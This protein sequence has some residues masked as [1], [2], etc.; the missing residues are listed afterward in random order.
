V[1][2]SDPRVVT[3]CICCPTDPVQRDMI[4]ECRVTTA[5]PVDVIVPDASE[6]VITPDAGDAGDVVEVDAADAAREDAALLMLGQA[7]SSGAQ[8]GTGFCVDEV[9]C[10]SAC[11]PSD[12][13]SCLLE[14]NFAGLCM[15]RPDPALK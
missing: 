10:N 4:P 12:Q 8:C 2:S 15:R 9:C 1:P 13:F 6:D 7:C 3:D 5:P 11:T 14:P